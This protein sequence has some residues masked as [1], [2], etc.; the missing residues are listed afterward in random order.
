EIGLNIVDLGLV[1][2]LSV[3]EEAKAIQV[4]MTLTTQFCPMG[5]FIVGSVEETLKDYFPGYDVEVELVFEP[6]WDAGMI[7]EGGKAFCEW[8]QESRRTYQNKDQRTSSKEKCHRK[9]IGSTQQLPERTWCA[10]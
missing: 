5:A 4:N 8:Y 10:S 6:R 7:S 9:P 1:Y 2:A 3:N